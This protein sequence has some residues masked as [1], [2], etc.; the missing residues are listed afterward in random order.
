ME[1]FIF[2]VAMFVGFSFFKI[3]SS[4][5]FLKRENG[6]SQQCTSVYVLPSP[7]CSIEY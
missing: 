4:M 2:I 5:L 3:L 6:I 7:V 1:N